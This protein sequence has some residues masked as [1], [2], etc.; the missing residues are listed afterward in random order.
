M[1]ATLVT[2]GGHVEAQDGAD[3]FL[4]VMTERHL[5]MIILWNT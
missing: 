3:L 2:D 4:R 1:R 5:L